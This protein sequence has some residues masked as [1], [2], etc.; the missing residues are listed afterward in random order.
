MIKTVIKHNVDF[1]L[2]KEPKTKKVFVNIPIV[3]LSYIFAIFI[4]ELGHC[5]VLYYYRL[6]FR[7]TYSFKG[8]PFVAIVSRIP[9]KIL[10]I[11]SMAGIFNQ[12]IFIIFCILFLNLRNYF[13]K[14]I[15]KFQ[16]F[17][18]WIIII[19]Y[20]FT[21]TFIFK[22]GDFFLL[23]SSFRLF[24]YFLIVCIGFVLSFTLYNYKKKFGEKNDK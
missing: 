17:V 3:F 4:H 24:Y 7:I 15:L 10:P 21:D 6:P 22:D 23:L 5:L 16:I 14:K 13:I 1:D 11:A 9:V 8:I 12:L 18:N 2:K 19:F 20:L